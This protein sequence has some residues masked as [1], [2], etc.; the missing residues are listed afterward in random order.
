MESLQS[1]D[2][3]AVSFGHVVP[4]PPERRSE[5]RQTTLLRIGKLTTGGHQRLCMI[6]NIS[7]AGAMLKLYQPI[8]VDTAV[9]VEITPDCPVAATVIWI[10]DD[11]AG[12]AFADP[13]DVLSALRGGREEGPYRR[14]TR[15]PRLKVV[16]PVRMC[17]EDIECAATL[18]DLSINGAKIATDQAPPRDAEIALFVDGL[19]PLTGRV[20][21]CRDGH[22]GVQFDIPVQVTVLA[23]WIG[24]LAA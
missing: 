9:Q 5:T 10:Q 17:V 6:R 16:R 3:T 19:P 7:S 4:Q 8:A 2:L 22:A 13:I 23:D 14:V 15:M 21:W 11:L 18:C 20:R 12:V 1:H 24:S